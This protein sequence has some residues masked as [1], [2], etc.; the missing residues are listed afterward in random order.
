MHQLIKNVGLTALFGSTTLQ[1]NTIDIMAVYTRNVA[2]ANGGRAGVTAAMNAAIASANDS[3]QKSNLETRLRLVHLHQTDYQESTPDADLT[4]L[5]SRRDGRMDEIHS[6]RDEKGADLVALV[7]DS[8]RWGRTAGIGYITQGN[9]KAYGFSATGF[10]FLTTGKTFAHE[11]GHNLGCGH[12]AGN[13]TGAFSYARGWRFTGNSG[14][15]S[16]TVMAYAPGRRI[17]LF[18]SPSLSFDGRP[19][20]VANQADNRRCLQTTSA[21]AARLLP[22]RVA[23]ATPPTTPTTPPPEP[24][25][26][27]K[28][29]DSRLVR[30][31][32]G[33]TGNGDRTVTWM[34]VL[35]D[36]DFPTANHEFL[37][38]IRL[39]ESSSSRRL[40]FNSP[41]LGGWCYTRRGTWPN[42]YQ[43]ST[44]TW[45]RYQVGSRNPRAFYNYSTGRTELR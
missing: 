20:G 17:D 45:K 28:P 40:Y 8:S 12:D 5:R 27:A 4:A 43:F 6:I 1:A 32:D 31:F 38:Q 34:G 37:G 26:T 35:K 21:N 41:D 15:Q 29:I 33:P 13:G 9:L 2:E 39:W 11:I 18:S 42:F 25:V 30:I 3:F 7:A 19:T 10:R 22:T 36:I 24:V 16:R 23:P 14:R 44:R